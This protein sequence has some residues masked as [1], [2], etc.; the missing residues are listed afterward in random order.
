MIELQ[1]LKDKLESLEAESTNLEALI[2]SNEK[3]QQQNRIALS[4]LHGASV[5]LRTLIE[6]AKPKEEDEKQ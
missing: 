4:E 6:E 5:V 2:A 3:V 1:K